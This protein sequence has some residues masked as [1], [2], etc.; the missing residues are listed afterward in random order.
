[1]YKMTHTD[2][3]KAI[4][5]IEEEE[6]ILESKRI[7]RLKKRLRENS[8]DPS[9]D[10]E[11]YEFNK[12]LPNEI[13]EMIEK[14]KT[15]NPKLYE[16]ALKIK[17][18]KGAFAFMREHQG[19]YVCMY[20]NVCMYVCMYVCACMYVCLYVCKHVYVCMY[21]YTCMCVVILGRLKQIYPCFDIW[22]FFM[23]TTFFL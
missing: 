21:A 8:D 11:T 17:D 2:K 10:I 7:F 3:E 12:N 15:T 22:I 13:N 16:E 9:I 23:A 18:V 14:L 6:A 1:M 4:K 20:A 5:M 19:L